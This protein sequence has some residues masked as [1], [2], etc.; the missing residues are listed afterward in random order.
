MKTRLVSTLL[1]LCCA[2]PAAATLCADDIVPA[3]TLLIP[4]FQVDLDACGED[5]L[6]TLISITNAAPSS[7][8]VHITFWTDWAAPTIN[9]DLYLT[10][11]DVQVL[12]LADAFCN[13]NLPI[14][15]PTVSPHGSM[16]DPPSSPPGCEGILPFPP[17]PVL[18]GALLA[19]FR[20]GHTGR[21]DA[22]FGGCAG[23][24]HGD[25][26]ARGYV[27]I[28]VVQ[29][30][31]LLF[32]SQPPYFETV[33][34]RDNHLMGEFLLFQ[35]L[36]GLAESYPAAHLE[37]DSAGDTLLPGDRTFYGRYVD[38]LA[39]DGREPLPT[40]FATAYAAGLTPA[41]ELLVWREHAGGTTAAC[42]G[43][44]D[45]LPLAQNPLLVFDHEENPTSLAVAI[46]LATNRVPLTDLAA[47]EGWIGLDESHE[48]VAAL[49]GDDRAQAWVA[50]LGESA[51]GPWVGHKAFQLTRSCESVRRIFTSGFESGDTSEWSSTT[52][53]GAMAPSNR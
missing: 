8:L 27:T 16:S 28:D 25:N 17:N 1:L 23:S 11:F 9:F 37:A 4:H 18:V 40:T 5:G 46:D 43:V 38:S 49:Y 13:G 15:G 33:A 26:V 42:G 36:A 47:G 32:P 30:C 35:P 31:S 20:N 41:A 10:G 6:N 29:Q 24:D 22:T 44:P 7:T 34:G 14:T 3:A 48:G 39:T 45:G 19:R 21:F 50:T 53:R 52:S 51:L 12:D 2:A